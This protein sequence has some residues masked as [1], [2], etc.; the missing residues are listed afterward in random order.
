VIPVKKDNKKYVIFAFIIILVVAIFLT[1]KNIKEKR[2][3]NF[4]EKTVKDT[5]SLVINITS[6]PFKLFQ[7]YH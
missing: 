7:R 3:L 2:K 5:T 1:C 6:K 4:F